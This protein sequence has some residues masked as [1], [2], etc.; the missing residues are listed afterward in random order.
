MAR[1]TLLTEGEIR[2]FMKLASLPAV[3]DARLTEFVGP[4]ET[5][6]E[7]ESSLEEMEIAE[8]EDEE[9]DLDGGEELDVDAELGGEEELG[10]DADVDA[11]LDGDAVDVDAEELVTRIAHDLESLARMAGVDVDVE[12]DAPDDLDGELEMDAELGAED[13]LGAA[14][15]GDEEEA[16]PM[17]EEEDIVNEV[18]RRVAS[19]M[20]AQESKDDM[21]SNLAERILNRITNAK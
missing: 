8:E 9:I 11:D 1:K 13:D 3:G 18:A 4:A 2:Q 14:E 17:M 21:V 12:D 6:G 15:L 20:K 7:D 10:M 16:A 19:R 5:V